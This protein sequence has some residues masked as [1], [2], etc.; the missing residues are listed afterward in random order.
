MAHFLTGYRHP[1]IRAPASR[2]GNM[3]LSDVSGTQP[4]LFTKSLCRQ[5]GNP[6]D[7]LYWGW[8]IGVHRVVLGHRH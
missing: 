5:G 3:L 1:V 4:A 6:L 2:Q 7:F 8:H